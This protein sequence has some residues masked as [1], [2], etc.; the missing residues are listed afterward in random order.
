MFGMLDYRAFQ[1]YR[2]IFFVPNVILFLIAVI[3]VPLGSYAI[4]LYFWKDYFELT[5]LA[6]LWLLGIL[7]FIILGLL[8]TLIFF[9]I[10][11]FFDFIFS[12]F[13]DVIPGDGRTEDEAQ[14]VL[15]SGKAGVH[16]LKMDKLNPKDWTDE[17]IY[18]QISN[19][20]WVQRLI[21]LSVT[22]KRLFKIRDHYRSKGQDN[23]LPVS[24]YDIQNLL[25]KHGLYVTTTES[26]LTANFM[27]HFILQVL[28]ML[29]LL[30][31]NPF[32]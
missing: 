29:Y 25:D 19:T 16:Q 12:I 4:A 31:E 23:D 11:R 30:M 21:Y 27:R 2:L 15:K 3:C 24:Y 22:K 1:L 9:L 17:M 10:Y 18:T 28:F 32:M 5:S 13:I 8:V 14:F 7:A 6:M 20:D 26:I